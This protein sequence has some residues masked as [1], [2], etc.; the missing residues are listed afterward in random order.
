MTIEGLETY[1]LLPRDPADVSLLVEALRA[2]PTLSD[3]DVV[4]GAKGP[5]AAPEMCNGLMVP[6]VAFDQIYSFDRQ[7]LIKAIPR[8]EKIPAKEFTSRQRSSST[9]S[10]K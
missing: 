10:S 1:I 5:I 2:N 8:P 7:A 6:I 4:I 3:L 9:E